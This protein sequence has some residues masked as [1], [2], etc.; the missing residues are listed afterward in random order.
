MPDRRASLALIAGLTLVSPSLL[1]AVAR[2]LVLCL[3]DT[4]APAVMVGISLGLVA[5][6]AFTA[7]RADLWHLCGL[8][9]H[10]VRTEVPAA[11][12]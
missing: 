11:D 12:A 1:D 2:R 10:S 7:C 4:W 6:V 9:V 8:P 5:F 3:P